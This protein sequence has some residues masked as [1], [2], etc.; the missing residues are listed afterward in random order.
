MAL[1]HAEGRAIVGG[2]GDPSTL[3]SFDL[4]SASSVLTDDSADSIY[5]RFQTMG[6]DYGPAFRVIRQTWLDD[7]QALTRLVLP[8]ATAKSERPGASSH[9]L[10]PSLVDGALQ[11]ALLLIAESKDLALPFLVDRVRI[12]APTTETCYAHVQAHE[13][14]GSGAFRVFDIDLYDDRG[15]SRRRHDRVHLQDRR[16]AAGSCRGVG[17]E[18]AG[19]ASSPA[20]RAIP[21]VFIVPRCGPRLCLI[22][23]RLCSPARC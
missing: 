4:A 12:L 13:S 11:T 2:R 14:G 7:R 10:Y 1:R 5:S 17:G 6:F 21:C 23:C 19:Q 3:G 20:P 18:L 9:F 8:P 16:R 22:S 15:A